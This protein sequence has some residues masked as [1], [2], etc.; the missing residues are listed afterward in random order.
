MI[1]PKIYLSGRMTGLP[2]FGFSKFNYWENYFKSIGY[3]VHN[4][5]KAFF[6]ITWLPWCVYIIFD[7]LILRYCNI[8]HIFMI[9]GWEKSTGACIEA[10]VADKY[11]IQQICEN[12][13]KE[14]FYDDEDYA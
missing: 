7:I 3:E 4:P 8:T 10:L 1:K 9:E 12:A 14:A 2:D 13:C 11:G 6:G 5:A